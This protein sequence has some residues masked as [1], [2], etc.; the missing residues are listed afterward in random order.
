M[1]DSRQYPR[2]YQAFAQILGSERLWVPLDRVNMKTPVRADRPE[3]RH[4]GMIHLDVDT[5]RPAIPS[6]VQGVLYLTDT[7]EDQD[8]FQCVPGFHRAF[9]AWVKSQPADRDR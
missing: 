2:V 4:T 3:W 5:S 7:A 1:W 9:D 6:G 8:G